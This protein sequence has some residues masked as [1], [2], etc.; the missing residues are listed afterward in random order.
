MFFHLSYFFDKVI[1]PFRRYLFEEMDDHQFTAELEVSRKSLFL[2]LRET[3]SGIEQVLPLAEV[4]P[5]SSLCFQYDVWES[6]LEGIDLDEFPITNKERLQGQIERLMDQIK[7]HRDLPCD[8]DED[9]NTRYF[10]GFSIERHGN[11]IWLNIQL[12]EN[13][14]QSTREFEIMEFGSEEEM[15][16]TMT[17]IFEYCTRNVSF[18][19]FDL[20]DLAEIEHRAM[21]VVLAAGEALENWKFENGESLTENALELLQKAEKTLEKALNFLESNPN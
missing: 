5:S 2:I 7:V 15:I 20:L 12:F 14:T 4:K 16:K 21:D 18:N 17:E 3:R 8:C 9:A 10:R 6:A 13:Q 11:S 19:G 1:K